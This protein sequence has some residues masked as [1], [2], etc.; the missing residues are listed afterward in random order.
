MYPVLLEIGRFK[1][2]SFGSFIALG[3]L[4]GSI[5]LRTLAAKQKLK[6]ISLF[7]AIL[8]GVIWGLIGARLGY[9]ILYSDQFP[10]FFQA[11]FVWQGNLLALTGLAVGFFAFY[12]Y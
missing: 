8:A 11:I 3:I 10:N 2:Y 6:K 5:L 4:A 1:F 12:R 9:Y 7:D